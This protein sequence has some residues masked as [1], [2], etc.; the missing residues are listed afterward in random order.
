MVTNPTHSHCQT[1]HMRLDQDPLTS[2]FKAPGAPL[3]SFFNMQGSVVKL[4]MKK[5]ERLVR[6]SKTETVWLG[7]GNS[8]TWLG[9]GKDHA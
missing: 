9:F 8:T 7:L 2:L 1:R 3:V 5:G 6:L 4:A